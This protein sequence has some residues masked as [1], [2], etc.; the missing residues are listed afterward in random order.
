MYWI[1]V[2]IGWLLSAAAFL[3][4]SKLL[5]G[6]RIGSFGTALMVSAV[7]SILHVVLHFILF[8]ILWILTFPLA[9]LTLGLLFFVVNAVI[10]WFTD[11]IV[12]D[13]NIDRTSTLIVAAVLLTIVNWIIRLVLFL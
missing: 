5:P 4:V 2:L 3:A 1:R 13:F 11:K 8:R 9:I 6:F 7:Y 10:L 12:E